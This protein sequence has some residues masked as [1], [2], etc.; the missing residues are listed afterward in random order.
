VA[1]LIARLTGRALPKTPWDPALAGIGGVKDGP[2]PA[3]EAGFPGSTNQTRTFKGASPR[4]VK[5]ESD[6]DTGFDQGF[7]G[8]QVRQAGRHYGEGWD[9]PRE[10]ME[11]VTPRPRTIASLRQSSAEW[12]GGVPLRSDAVAPATHGAGSGLNPLMPAQNAGGHSTYDT[13]TPRTSR[14]PDISGGVPGSQNVRNTI[15][16]R[17]KNPPGQLHTYRSK[18]R[19]DQTPLLPKGQAADGNVKQ[20]L[21]TTEV[22]V[23]NRFTWNQGGV[24]TWSVERQMP[25]TGRGDGARGAALNGTRYYAEGPPIAVNAGLGSYGV[26]RLR[27]GKRPVG[28]TEPAPWTSQFYDTTSSVGTPDA[29]GPGG[30]AP[31][32]IYTSP[33]LGRGG[34]NATGRAG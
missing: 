21:G 11:V 22:T 8:V 20:F 30:Q 2:G 31:V 16:Q 9:N 7:D 4:D 17:Y 34:L 13:E 32:D 26:A 18:Y 29:P 12:F 14:Q 25:Y 33:D 3:G 23:L 5:V 19:A 10:T 15:A 6:S 28:C 27:G 24:Q 1:G